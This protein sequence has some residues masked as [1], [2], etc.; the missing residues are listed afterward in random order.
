MRGDEAKVI[1]DV[2]LRTEPQ[3]CRSE[4]DCDKLAPS[5]GVLKIGNEVRIL[6]VISVGVD[7][8][9]LCLPQLANASKIV[10]NV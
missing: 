8:V 7:K 3:K 10:S 5:I 4:D 2:Y 6:D 9:K 1:G